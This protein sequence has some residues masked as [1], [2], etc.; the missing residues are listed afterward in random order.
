M[1]VTVT[2]FDQP[3]PLVSLEEAKVA[4]GEYSGDRDVLISGL[5][6]AAQGEM[7]GPKGW[8]GMSVAVQGLEYIADDFS[9]PIVLPYGPVIDPVE[10][11]YLDPDGAEQAISSSAFMVTSKGEVKLS[12]GA[13]WPAVSSSDDA[14]R[15]RYYAG[16]SDTFDPRIAMMKT[17]IILHV[18]MTLDGVDREPARRALESIVRPMWVPVC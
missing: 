16:I 9:A 15:I 7:D 3:Y 2:V 4:L 6:M 14:V 17:A 10:V 8:L 13:S 11:Y 12:N 18:R 5:I 1:M